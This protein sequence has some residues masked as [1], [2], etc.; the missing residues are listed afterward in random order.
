VLAAWPGYSLLQR[1]DLFGSLRQPVQEG[2]WEAAE[3]RLQVALDLAS[4]F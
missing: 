1:Q 2:R 3:E 4:L